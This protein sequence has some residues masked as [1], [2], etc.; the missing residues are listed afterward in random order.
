MCLSLSFKK[1]LHREILH[2]QHKCTLARSSFNIT[3]WT[4]DES[5][6][7]IFLGSP[8]LATF[9]VALEDIRTTEVTNDKV[10]IFSNT[11]LYRRYSRVGMC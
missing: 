11:H 5:F 4:N 1:D 7:I 2:G 9:K 3:M 6:P 8:T 10:R